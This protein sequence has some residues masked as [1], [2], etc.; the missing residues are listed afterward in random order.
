MNRNTVLFGPVT[1]CL[2]GENLSLSFSQ[3]ALSS[4]P[5]G[6]VRGFMLAFAWLSG[7][8]ALLPLKSQNHRDETTDHQVL[9]V[10]WPNTRW[11]HLYFYVFNHE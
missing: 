1:F 7:D 8:V 11:L 6:A 5:K 9:D 4:V 10:R 3:D 2:S